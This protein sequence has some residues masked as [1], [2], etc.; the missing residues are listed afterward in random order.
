VRQAAARLRHWFSDACFRLVHRNHLVYNACWEDPRL[1]EAALQLTARDRVLVITSAGCNALHYA[2]LGPERV[3]AVDVN[4]R[5]S[6]LLQ[7]KLAGIRALDF[8]TYFALFGQGRVREPE[9]LY[10]RRLRPVLPA[11]A[12]K[13]WDRRITL[14]GGNSWRRSFYFR[15][16]AGAFA[17][18][19]CFHID[20]VAKVRAEVNE[21]LAAD[22]VEQQ[23]AIYFERLHGQF[24]RPFLRWA[25]RRDAALSL[26]G[27]PRP[28]RQQVERYYPGGIARFIEDS[29]EA[30]F[31]RLP[32]ADN[33]FW[34]VY[35]QGEYSRAC[36]PEYLKP[37][38]F[39]RLQA[40]LVE[41]ISAQT[42]SIT[43]FL[44]SHEDGPISRFVLL[45]HMD[46]LAHAKTP[47][48]QQEWQAI[49]RRAAPRAR[50]LWRSGGLKVDFI[51]PLEVTVGGARRSV[52]D[53]LHYH[54][55]LAE[56]LHAK[57]RVHTYGSFYIADLRF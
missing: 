50:I 32:L 14:F 39:A 46:W 31:T 7:L 47:L 25:V 38:Q 6:A 49:V 19:V 43:Q 53:L 51:D 29:L 33:Y 11:F 9:K 1:D 27:V 40:G 23:R 8:E 36:C 21:L 16:A 37:D 2:L 12:R 28:Q 41:R 34:R 42:C 18:A 20:R 10:R 17:R 3:Y 30:V 35:M 22:S 13:Y 4:P 26:L 57:D 55:R 54:T 15:G 48:L 45:D 52:G 44:E 56:E 5:Q 24:W